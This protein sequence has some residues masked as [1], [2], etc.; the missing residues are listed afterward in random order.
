MLRFVSLIVVGCLLIIVCKG[1][2]FYG[3]VC[4]VGC[5]V[6]VVGGVLYIFIGKGLVVGW[7]VFFF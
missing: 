7:M 1:F 5:F 4:K 3:F 2:G 6:L